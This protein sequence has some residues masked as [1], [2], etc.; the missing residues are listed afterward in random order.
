MKVIVL[1]LAKGIEWW[2]F[3]G[4]GPPIQCDG[5]KKAMQKSAERNGGN[6]G[7]GAEKRV[8][9]LRERIALLSASESECPLKV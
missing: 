2:H 7:G 5:A 1:A 3:R 4:K 8:L 9:S 6:G